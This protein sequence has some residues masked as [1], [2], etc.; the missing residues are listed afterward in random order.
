MAPRI[1]DTLARVRVCRDAGLPITDELRNDIVEC[2]EQAAGAS[3]LRRQ[4]D[5]LI[6]R[7][8]LLLPPAGAWRQAE[9]LADEAQQLARVWHVMRNR[10]AA[11][12]PATPRACLHA[13]GLLAALP[14]SQR[15]FHRVLYPKD[16]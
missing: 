9:A 4:R 6:R 5:M 16:Y 7:A 13:A 2:L 11:C 12:E 15:H 14:K 1:A 10:P 8:A 3:A